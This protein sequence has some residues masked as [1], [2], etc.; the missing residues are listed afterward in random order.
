MARYAVGGRV[1]ASGNQRRPAARSRVRQSTSGRRRREKPLEW[2][3]LVLFLV[4]V[5]FLL[6]VLAKTGIRLPHS[7]LL[8]R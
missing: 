3:W 2:R 6:I 7:P 4:V 1:A 8:P 5:V